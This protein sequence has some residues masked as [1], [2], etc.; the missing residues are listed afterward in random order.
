MR[1]V[2]AAV[3]FDS[4]SAVAASE[5]LKCQVASSGHASTLNTPTSSPAS[6]VLLGRRVG[7]RADGRRQSQPS[8]IVTTMEVR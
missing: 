2:Q 5:P 7:N 4:R 3:A 8:P 6:G 1:A